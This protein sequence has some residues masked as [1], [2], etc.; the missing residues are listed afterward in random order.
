MRNATEKLNDHIRALMLRFATPALRDEFEYHLEIDREDDELNLYG[1]L[2]DIDDREADNQ[3]RKL[4][5]PLR[6]IYI[7]LG[8]YRPVSDEELARTVTTGGRKYAFQ[9]AGQK[10]T[11]DKHPEGGLR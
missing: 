9:Q 10:Y 1:I 8:V 6:Q 4:I 3:S 5:K 7:A 2:N 11:F